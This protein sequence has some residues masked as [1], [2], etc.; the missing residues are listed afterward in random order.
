MKALLFSLF[1]ACALTISFAIADEKVYVK[2]IKID[3]VTSIYDA[4][5]FRANINSWPGIVGER[6]PIR[7]LGIDAPEIKGKCDQEKIKARTA[8]Q[9]AVDKLRSAKTIELRNIQ[10]GKY[11][12]LL[13][14]VYVDNKNLADLLIQSGNARPYD[15]GTR[16]GWC[17]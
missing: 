15:G 17:P 14:D 4:D 13:A 7:I 2:R 11:F 10:R 12:R 16:K 6:I 8:K 3:E 1:V 9:F 5:T